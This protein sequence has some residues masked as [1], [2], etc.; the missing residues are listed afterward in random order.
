MNACNFFTELKR[1]NACKPARLASRFILR[2]KP[3]L[4]G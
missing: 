1:R 3:P 4:V 2:E